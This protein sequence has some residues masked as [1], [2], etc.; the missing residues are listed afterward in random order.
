VIK[1]LALKLLFFRFLLLVTR[2]FPNLLDLRIV[3]LDSLIQK[4]QLRTN[5]HKIEVSPH[6]IKNSKY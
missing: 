2:I 4:P 6:I 5:I 1:I 3:L